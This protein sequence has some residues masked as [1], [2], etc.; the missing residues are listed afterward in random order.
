VLPLLLGFA[1]GVPSEVQENIDPLR[2][3]VLYGTT[4]GERASFS[5]FVGIE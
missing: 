4:E 2:S 3:V 1:G 5:L